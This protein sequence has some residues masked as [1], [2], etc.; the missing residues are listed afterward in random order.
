MRRRT[1]LQAL[2]APAVLAAGCAE[3]AGSRPG[4]GPSRKPPVKAAAPLPYQVAH[5]SRRT[6]AVSLTFHGQGEPALTKALLRA[7]EDG[8]AKVTVM[9]VGSWLD[10]YPELAKRILDGGHEIGNHTQNHLEIN[11]LSEGEARAEIEQCARRLKVLTGS[12]GK[13]F[14]P[15]RAQRATALVQRLARE[16]GYPHCLSYDVDSRDNTDPGAAAVRRYVAGD[17][18][19]GSVISLHIGHEGTIEALPAILDDLKGRG[20]R[21]VTAAELLDA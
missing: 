19:R 16:A 20:L 14:R 2:L 21:A 1:A 8:G 5:A 6:S 11:A 12:R 7:A 9:A 4:S 13:W 18:E 15:S 10:T 17:V 3:S